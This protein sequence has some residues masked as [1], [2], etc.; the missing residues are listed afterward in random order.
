MGKRLSRT[1]KLE[2]AYEMATSFKQS[3]LDLTEFHQ[4]IWELRLD[5]S[6]IERLASDWSAP[7]GRTLGC[8][9]EGF[10]TFNHVRFD[11]IRFNPTTRRSPSCNIKESFHDGTFIFPSADD[12]DF[13]LESK[14]FDYMRVND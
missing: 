14:L 9:C 3:E 11:R 2:K 1:A 4:E 7:E 6:K 5:V 10:L 12:V 8:V 13:V